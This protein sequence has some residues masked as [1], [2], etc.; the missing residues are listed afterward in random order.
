MKLQQ[1]E[2]VLSELFKQDRGVTITFLSKRLRKLPNNLNK[3][4]NQLV[5]LGLIRRH[6]K[7]NRE[8]HLILTLRGMILADISHKKESFLEKFFEKCDEECE[9]DK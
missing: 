4:V 5:D 9:D 2:Q 3:T 8:K 7:N 1:S 6:Q